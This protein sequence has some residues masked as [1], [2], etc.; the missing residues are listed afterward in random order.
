MKKAAILFFS[1]MLCLVAVNAQIEDPIK[2][3]VKMLPVEGNEYDISFQ[4]K[5]DAGWHLYD[6]VLPEGGPIATTFE[7]EKKEGVELVGTVKASVKP[8]TKPYFRYGFKL[9]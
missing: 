5:I 2:W 4:A 9:E 6:L 3:T 1:W 7:F 8:I